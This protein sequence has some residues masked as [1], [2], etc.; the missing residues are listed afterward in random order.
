MAKPVV[1]PENEIL[2]Y[3]RAKNLTTPPE[4]FELSD[5]DQEMSKILSRTDIDDKTKGTLYYKAL[6]KFRNLFKNL[7]LHNSLIDDLRDV[8]ERVNEQNLIDLGDPEYN[9]DSMAPLQQSIMPVAAA[10]TPVPVPRAASTPISSKKD[11]D[12]TMDS[13]DDILGST[14]DLSSLIDADNSTTVSSQHADQAGDALRQLNDMDPV[15]KHIFSK[16]TKRSKDNRSENFRVTRKGKLEYE[17]LKKKIKFSYPVNVWIGIMNYFFSRTRA[18]QPTFN[19]RK[20]LKATR[21]ISNLLKRRNVVPKKDLEDFPNLAQTFESDMSIARKL[22]PA[23]AHIARE[24]QNVVKNS[25]RMPLEG[26][27]VRVNFKKWNEN[28]LF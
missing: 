10:S 16:M 17:H 21:D 22:T 15:A 24:L 13:E 4:A 7:P 11:D 26:S 14:F 8:D 3:Y 1:V 12:E 27:G 28:L 6:V 20:N 19:K 23:S 18:P 9:N 25:P 2:K 5:L